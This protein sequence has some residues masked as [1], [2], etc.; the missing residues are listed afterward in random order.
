MMNSRL[1]AFL[2]RFSAIFFTFICLSY[3]A[4]FLLSINGRQSPF[5]ICYTFIYPFLML[6]RIFSLWMNDLSFFALRYLNLS[7]AC[8][9]FQDVKAFTE[10]SG[11]LL[12]SG[13]YIS[14]RAGE[15]FIIGMKALS[16]TFTRPYD[17]I[18]CYVLV[19]KRPRCVL[20]A[21]TR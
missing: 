17:L 8:M 9:C 12:K 6:L 11:G 19:L 15:W 4:N 2:S 16:A 3:H 10:G 18:S 21:C 14:E 20:F 7:P 13:S 1:K 5:L